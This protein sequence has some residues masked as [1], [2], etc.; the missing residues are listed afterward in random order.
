MRSHGGGRVMRVGRVMARLESVAALLGEMLASGPR[1]AS[2]RK[3]GSD[4]PATGTAGRPWPSGTSQRDQ[5]PRR[6]LS[7][8]ALLAVLAVSTA[9]AGVASSASAA[10]T[11][12]TNYKELYRPQF[13]FTPAKNWMNDP[14][15]LIWYKGEYHLFFQYNPSGNTWGNISWGHAVSRDLVPWQ[16]RPPA[17]PAGDQ[18][19]VF[20]GRGVMGQDEETGVAI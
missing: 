15:G 19:R 14:N 4:P 16:A 9:S 10:T 3:S 12:S 5:R 17:F 11:S 8:V 18:A 13:H 1:L 2:K 7:I 20:V 6:H